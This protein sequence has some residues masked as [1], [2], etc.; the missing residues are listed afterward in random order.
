M[1]RLA[2][3]V[4]AILAGLFAASMLVTPA[5]VAKTHRCQPFPMAWTVAPTASPADPRTGA[6]CE[7]GACHDP[8][9]GATC[10]VGSCA[11]L[12]AVKDDLA[13]EVAPAHTIVFAMASDPIAWGRSIP[14]PLGPPRS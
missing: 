3:I 7:N 13:I 5:A 6:P 2:A 11:V 1:V 9:G 8:A 4:W 14:P 12:L 10:C